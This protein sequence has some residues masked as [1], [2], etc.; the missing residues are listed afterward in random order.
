MKL[1]KVHLQEIIRGELKKVYEQSGNFQENIQALEEAQEHLYQAIDLIEFG[2]RGTNQEAHANAYIIP[3]LKSWAGE[4][5]G[6]DTSIP[7]YIEALSQGDVEEMNTTGTGASMSPGQGAQ[8]ATP[9][10]FKKKNKNN[11]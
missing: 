2:V 8:Y 7:D 11:R 4:G 10:A 9:K 1:T 6:Y 3:H 5:A